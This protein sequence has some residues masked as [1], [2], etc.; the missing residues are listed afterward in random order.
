MHNPS[1]N[2]KQTFS[3]RGR[4]MQDAVNQLKEQLG[5]DAVIV[6]TRRG[7]DKQG[8]FVEISARYG[9]SA[10]APVQPQAR[11]AVGGAKRVTNAYAQTAIKTSPSA[12]G[13]A[14][15]NLK[16]GDSKNKPF[17]ERAAWLASQIQQREQ[18]NPNPA[19]HPANATSARSLPPELMALREGALP[20]GSGSVSQPVAPSNPTFHGQ[21][22]HH[23][24]MAPHYNAAQAMTIMLGWS[25]TIT[26]GWDLSTM[27]G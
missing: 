20:P 2:G 26:L 17:A 7:S 16:V 13:A 8:P 4:S 27:L 21:P 14:L 19:A 10:N 5:I 23:P 6:S 1:N 25:I 3:F 9:D 15:A 11:P 18:Q 24:V 12:I 22:A